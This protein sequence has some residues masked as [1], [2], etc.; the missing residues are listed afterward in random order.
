MAGK[1]YF[2]NANYQTWIKAP[3]SGMAAGSN[4]YISQQQLLSGR[5][6]I[7]RSRAS[8]RTFE[9]SWVGGLDQAADGLEVINDFA[10]GFY[11]DGPFYWVDPFAM[12]RNILPPHWSAP[13]L[14]ERDWPKLAN[15]GT[16]IYSTLPSPAGN[17]FPYK[18]MTYSNTGTNTRV[19][20][21]IVPDGYTFHFGWHNLHATDLGVAI[22]IIDS[23]GGY[24]TEMPYSMLAGSTTRTNFSVNGGT[25][26]KMV[27]IYLQDTCQIVSMT[28]LILPTGASVPTGNFVTGKGTTALEFTK[29]PSIEYYSSALNGGQVGMSASFVE[30]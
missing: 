23:T 29:I 17:N 12:D 4:G 15:E 18:Y 10:N 21:I 16:F 25:A 27:N 9:P 11:G 7:K 28:G 22:D 13:H 2:G 8:S 3:T 30:V 14:T 19:L 6:S 1:V 5:T 20:S 26:C 24:T